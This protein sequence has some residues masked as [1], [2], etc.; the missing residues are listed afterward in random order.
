MKANKWNYRSNT[1]VRLDW[2]LNMILYILYAL[3]WPIIIVSIRK[4]LCWCWLLHIGAFICKHKFP[5]Y[6]KKIKEPLVQTS[7][8][9]ILILTHCQVST[10]Q[11]FN[12]KL[13]SE[14]CGYLEDIRLSSFHI[15]YIYFVQYFNPRT[16]FW[17]SSTLLL[18][19][20]RNWNGNENLEWASRAYFA[21]KI[22]LLDKSAI[23]NLQLLHVAI[24]FNQ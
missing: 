24:R 3:K 8:V 4:S 13:I 20:L 15:F 16:I 9:I 22:P 23:L 6:K 17:G 18:F 21:S 7:S 1:D 11:R 10:I 12:Q 5:F 19:P 14:S 2:T